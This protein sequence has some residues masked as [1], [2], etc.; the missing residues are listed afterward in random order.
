MQLRV[1]SWNAENRV[2]SAL[3]PRSHS[4]PLHQLNNRTAIGNSSISLFEAEVS[5]LY[6]ID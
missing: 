2:Y 6:P 5:F 3:N 4:Q 1:R